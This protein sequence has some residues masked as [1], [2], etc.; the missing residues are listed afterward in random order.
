MVCGH[1]RQGEPTFM[2]SLIRRGLV[3][4][5]A[6]SDSTAPKAEEAAGTKKK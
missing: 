3:A 6:K 1:F 5:P 4:E 2:P